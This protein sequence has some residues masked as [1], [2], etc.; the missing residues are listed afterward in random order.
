MPEPIVVDNMRPIG[1]DENVRGKYGENCNS[2]LVRKML[3]GE[4]LRTD[5]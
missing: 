1:L 2:A 4:P 5:T 3:L